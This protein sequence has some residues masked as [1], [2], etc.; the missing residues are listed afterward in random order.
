MFLFSIYRSSCVQQKT[1][2]STHVTR[3]ATVGLTRTGCKNQMFQKRNWRVPRKEN[4]ELITKQKKKKNSENTI[5][6]SVWGVGDVTCGALE[7]QNK[8]NF[9]EENWVI[10]NR[11][12][13]NANMHSHMTIWV[14]ICGAD[15]KSW[16]NMT[17]LKWWSG[18]RFWSKDFLKLLRSF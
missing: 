18:C 16:W 4:D 14:T 11:N 2:A 3:L 17:G 12:V 5:P 13:P 1:S 9:W 8:G 10:L 7:R 6:R 15:V